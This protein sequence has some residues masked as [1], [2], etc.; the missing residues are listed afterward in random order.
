MSDACTTDETIY[1]CNLCETLFEAGVAD[2]MDGES[3][4]CPQ[5]GFLEADPIATNDVSDEDVVIRRSTKF[6]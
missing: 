6:R 1:R 4:R 2:D 3:P 5:C